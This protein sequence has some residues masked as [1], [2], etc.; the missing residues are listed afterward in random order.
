MTLAL[1]SE[2]PKSIA[3][4]KI[5]DTSL[6]WE[7]LIQVSNY[8]W[9]VVGYVNET[10]S[11]FAWVSRASSEKCCRLMRAI[12]WTICGTSLLSTCLVTELLTAAGKPRGLLSCC[13]FM[14]SPLALICLA[15]GG[16]SWWVFDLFPFLFILSYY[17]FIGGR[18]STDYN[19]YRL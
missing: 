17:Y 14:T 12:G 15:L 18:F 10:P 7:K 2:S 3:A 19:C 1:C 11:L 9:L 4:K 16:R 8:P 5:E 13:A 6:F